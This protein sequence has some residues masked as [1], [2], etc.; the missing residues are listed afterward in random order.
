MIGARITDNMN[1]CILKKNG[2]LMS[3]YSLIKKLKILKGLREIIE[4]IT[5]PSAWEYFIFLSNSLVVKLSI[6][7]LNI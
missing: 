5:A 1:E 6:S 2:F 3:F 7:N 4:M